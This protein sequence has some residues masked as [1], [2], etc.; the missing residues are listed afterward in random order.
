MRGHFLLIFLLLTSFTAAAHKGSAKGQI[1]DGK[2]GLPL[3]GV[4]IYIKQH[5][6]SAITD[7]FGA[8]F[9]TGIEPGKYAITIKHVGYEP[10]E[11]NI[12]IEDGITTDISETMK[13]NGVQLTDVTI[14]A[15]K[16]ATLRLF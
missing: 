15:K 3:E 5:N 14:N 13:P 6:V 7:M 4:S 8:F 16:D 2:S 1:R 9:L 12:Q 11:K 10:I